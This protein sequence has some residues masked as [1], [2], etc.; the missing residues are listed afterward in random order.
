MIGS[1]ETYLREGF[2]RYFQNQ[3]GFAFCG[4]ANQTEEAIALINAKRPTVVVI[5]NDL[6]VGEIIKHT[7][8]STAKF[9]VTQRG[10]TEHHNFM[11]A[12]KSLLQ[13]AKGFITKEEQPEV[14]SSAIQ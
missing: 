11:S 9:L 1:V 3:P 14:F 2:G 4:E 5:E 8:A 13:G 7:E 12:R 10:K 6:R